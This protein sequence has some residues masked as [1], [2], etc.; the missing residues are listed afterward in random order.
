MQFLSTYF[1]LLLLLPII[2]AFI[3]VEIHRS[4]IYE[5]NSS[6][7]YLRNISSIMNVDSCAWECS[8]DERC[9][10]A[11]YFH[12][13]TICSLFAESCTVGNIDSLSNIQ[14]SVICYSRDKNTVAN[15]ATTMSPIVNRM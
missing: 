5:T 14:A 12:N 4:A 15:C 1:L 7:A 6:C 3:V 2:D 13:E 10:T 11:V 9:Q 8:Y